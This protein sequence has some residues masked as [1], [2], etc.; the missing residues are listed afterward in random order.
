MNVYFCRKI[1]RSTSSPARIVGSLVMSFILWSTNPSLWW[2]GIPGEPKVIKNPF[3][4]VWGPLL[5]F[6]G[7]SCGTPEAA[8]L[9]SLQV[10]H[11]RWLQLYT[12]LSVVWHILRVF[13]TFLF[14]FPEWNRN[15]IVTLVPT[16]M[17]IPSIQRQS[18]MLELVFSQCCTFPCQ[19][20][21]L[22]LILLTSALRT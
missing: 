20:Y 18:W 1:F 3:T 15:E 9:F 4:L 10:F 11:H 22:K 6:L 13:S 2:Y 12:H 17:P 14:L 8:A 7:T 5:G 19:F 16:V 21:G